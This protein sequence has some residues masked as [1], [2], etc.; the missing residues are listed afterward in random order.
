MPRK[1]FEI[2]ASSFGALLTVVLVLAAAGGFAANAFINKQVGDQL[3]AQ[4]ITF[5]AVGSEALARPGAGARLEPHAGQKLVSGK[6]A[7]VFADDLIAEDLKV[8]AGGRTYA[9]VSAQSRAN[10]ADSKLAGQAQT[11]FKGEALRGMLL[12]AYAFWQMGDIARLAAWAALA[13]AVVVGVATLMGFRH[14]RQVS[15]VQMILSRSP[16]PSFELGSVTA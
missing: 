5:P 7:K 3:S 9:E 10:P 4:N 13:M 16:K 12:T 2:V 1:S 6:Q 14:A 15:P 8:I 11:L